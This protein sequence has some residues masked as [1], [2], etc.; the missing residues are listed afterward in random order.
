MNV[1][2]TYNTNS[3]ISIKKKIDQHELGHFLKNWDYQET[4]KRILQARSDAWEEGEVCPVPPAFK[5]KLW[6]CFFPFLS[7]LV[8]VIL[9][10]PSSS[11]FSFLP[12]TI[13]FLS[14]SLLS[15]PPLSSW[16]QKLLPYWNRVAVCEW[17]PRPW[18]QRG[19]SFLP[20]GEFKHSSY[21]SF[22]S[23]IKK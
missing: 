15:L 8:F 20:N 9:H 21:F 3:Y 18:R 13:S 22:Q 17:L 7:F 5:W 2:K 6:S 4:R 23:T 10:L 19:I 11:S 12:S 16:K 1:S 14:F